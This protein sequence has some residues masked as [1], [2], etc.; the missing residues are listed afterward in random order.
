[1]LLVGVALSAG[2]TGCTSSSEEQGNT[3]SLALELEIGDVTVDEVDWVIAGGDM[4]PMS[5]TINTSA[6]GSTASVEVFGLPPGDDYTISLS[7]TSTDGEATCEGAA[8]FAV[9]AGAATGVMVMLN[10]KI[11]TGLGGVRA[12]GK[13]N[14]C[15]EL[16]KVVVSPL[17]T[18]VGNDITLDAQAFDVEGDDVEFLWTAEGGS[19]ADDSAASTSYTCGEIG[20]GSITVT[21]SDDGFGHCDSSWTVAVTC[22]EGDGGGGDDRS[23]YRIASFLVC[24]QLDAD[25]NV[26]DETAS[27]IVAASE[28]GNTLIYTDSPLEVAGFVDITDP[29]APA[30]LGLLE[31]PGEP[32]S[33]AVA[34]PY[35]LVAVNTSEDFINTSGDLLVIDIATQTIVRDLPLG[36]QPDSVATS[37]DGTFAAIAIE[38]ER[39]EDLEEQDGRPP[40]L[41]PGYLVVVDIASDN[42][43]DWTTTE[44]NL[45]GLADLF[46]EDPEPEYVDINEDNVAVVTLQENNHIVLV[47]LTTA[48]VV[49]DFSAGTVDLTGVDLTEDDPA[50]NDNQSILQ[51]ES[52]SAVPREPDGVTWIGTELFAT[53]DEGDLDG[54]SRGFTIFDTDGTVVHT[55]GNTNDQITAR[56]GHYPDARSGNK[57][58]EPENADFGVYGDD[59]LLIVTSERSS[60]LFVYDVADP[61][62]PILTQV[63]PAGTGP[64]GTLAL[65]SRD[66]LI[67]A[68]EEDSR[69]DKIRSVLNIY[70]YGEEDPTYPT[71]QSTD[72][73][74]GSPIPFAALSGLAA[75]ASQP[76][77]MYSVEDSFFGSN[78]IFGIDITTS[79][80]TLDTEITIR[81]SNDELAGTATD[82]AGNDDDVFSSADLAAL[83]NLD[84]DKS[85]NIDP[86][87]IDIAFDGGF[88][89]ASE[90]SGTVGDPDRPVTSLNFIFKTNADGVIEDV[91]RLPDEINA[92]QLRFGFEGIAEYEGKA[93]VA[94]QRTWTALGDENPRIGI[95]DVA[96]ETW[97][98]LFYPLDPVESQNGGWVGLSDITSLGDG[99]FLVVERDNQGGP[100]AA[101]KRL[102]TF[103]VDGVE[104]GGTVEKTLVQDLLASGSLTAT[105]GLPAE[106]IE[107]S[108][109]T[110]SGDVYIVNDNDGVDDNSGEINLIN[111]GNLLGD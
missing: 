56:V 109:V 7:A 4:E 64:E 74:D 27:E 95:Y 17:Q 10:C 5:G 57:G 29:S 42:V 83:I 70:A 65:T 6:P 90:G 1:M 92:G 101:V 2:T 71:L 86:E 21:V 40:Q 8:D 88:W 54:G 13:F 80:A 78:R 31:L 77:R 47:D 82:D 98:F 58:N 106:K 61:A 46:P 105:N 49:G 69:D 34:G 37:P 87:G 89:I 94:F 35:A 108:A 3:G 104:E 107:G 18:S 99:S 23:F 51:I 44:V 97:S 43:D 102:Y 52:V 68:S 15:A 41:P 62:A 20:D 59:E 67:A 63:L 84:D 16:S 103:S 39:D 60:V 79:P 76:G 53:A 100:D 91:I 25:C 110:D 36:G 9:E 85:V 38:N 24:S 66:L 33:V 96:T 48:T 81:D 26:D 50:I 73:Q 72:R 11:P 14:I 45:E 32:T 19:I 93:Y 28:D 12:N 55:S 22:V 75:D 111:L 30:G